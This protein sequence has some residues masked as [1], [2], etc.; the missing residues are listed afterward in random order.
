VLGPL[1]LVDRRPSM[2]AMNIDADIIGKAEELRLALRAKLGVRGRDFAQ[3]V[4]RAG[5]LLPNKLRK[6]AAVIVKAQ[7]LGGHPKLMRMVDMTA[8]NKAHLDISTFLNA[9]DPKE[10]RRTRMLRWGGGIVFNLIVVAMCFVIWL[11]WSGN[12]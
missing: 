3:A 2:K 10:R 5:R 1:M 12:L 11:V 8:L 6:Q 9:I 7:G 4:D